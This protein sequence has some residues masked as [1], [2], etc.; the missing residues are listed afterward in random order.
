MDMTCSQLLAQQPGPV[1]PRR[2][3]LNLL[4]LSTSLAFHVALPAA[5]LPWA[6][7]PHVPIDQ[8]AITEAVA[9]RQ[10]LSKGLTARGL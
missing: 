7:A 8:T 10:M 2:K 4:S 1:H 9:S 6:P 3:L 5:L